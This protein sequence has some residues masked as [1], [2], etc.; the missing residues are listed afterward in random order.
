MTKLKHI[1][2]TIN[3]SNKKIIKDYYT[4]YTPITESMMINLLSHIKR[5]FEEIIK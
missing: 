2:F 1:I 3:A 5:F 4:P